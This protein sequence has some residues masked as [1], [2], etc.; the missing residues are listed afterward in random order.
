MFDIC[1]RRILF[2]LYLT[3]NKERKKERRKEDKKKMNKIKISCLVFLTLLR[4]SGTYEVD[5]AL[6]YLNHVVSKVLHYSALFFQELF[7]YLMYRQP[8]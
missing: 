4:V 5:I 6:E 3:K 1:I 8:F 7:L 2:E